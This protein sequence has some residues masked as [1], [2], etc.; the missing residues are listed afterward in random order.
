MGSF[1]DYSIAGPDGTHPT[2]AG[3]Q[4]MANAWFAGIQDAYASCFFTPPAPV[5]G[6]NDTVGNGVKST[7]CEKIP[8]NADGPHEIMV[9]SGID[10]GIYSYVSLEKPL[11]DNAL[12]FASPQPQTR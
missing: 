9:G 1:T 2:D 6:V 10:D 8:G 11:L 7:T 12:S 5:D 4:K 3:Y